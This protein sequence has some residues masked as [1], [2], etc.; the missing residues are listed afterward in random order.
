MGQA[1]FRPPTVAGWKG[2]RAWINA[3]TWL[4]RHN[5]LV[6]FAEAHGGEDDELSIDLA[7]AL[8]EPPAEELGRTVVTALVPGL[9]ESDLARTIS[10]ASERAP[11]RDAALV[12]ATALVLTSPEYHLY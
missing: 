8:G 12:R 11:D 2:G 9:E 1:L 3:G 7:S 4:A 10:A 5:A 6:R